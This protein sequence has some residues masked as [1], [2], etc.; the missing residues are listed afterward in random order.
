MSQLENATTH[1]ANFNA[2]DVTYISSLHVLPNHMLY[3]DMTMGYKIMH[4]SITINLL[5]AGNLCC[6]SGRERG[7]SVGTAH[8]ID[9]IFI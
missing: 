9:N 2:S 4:A 6:H 3:V 5:H 7:I 1:S 8:V